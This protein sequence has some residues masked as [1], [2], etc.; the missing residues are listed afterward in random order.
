[1]TILTIMEN[2]VFTSLLFLI[3]AIN[4]HQ[5]SR[6]QFQKPHFSISHVLMSFGCLPLMCCSEDFLTFLC[7]KIHLFT[8]K[9]FLYNTW[10]KTLLFLCKKHQ[11]L[12]L[13]KLQYKCPLIVIFT[14]VRIIFT[15]RFAIEQ[16]LQFLRII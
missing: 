6:Q 2:V 9:S 14:S 4:Y 10:K 1:M 3:A 11:F 12:Q 13:S 5:V 8:K 7:S 16:A 15:P